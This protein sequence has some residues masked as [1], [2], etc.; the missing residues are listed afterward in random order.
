MRTR[1]SVVAFDIHTALAP[2]PNQSGPP[3][4]A[5]LR[6]DWQAGDRALHGCEGS[7]SAKALSTNGICEQTGFRFDQ[8]NSES[9][10]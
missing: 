7:A 3:G 1:L 10:D 9:S 4:N 6:C 5:N 2:I 8:V